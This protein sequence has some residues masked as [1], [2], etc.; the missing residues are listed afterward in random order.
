MNKNALYTSLSRATHEDLIHMDELYTGIY[1]PQECMTGCIEST[2]FTDPVWKHGKIY[3]VKVG[4]KY[5][6]GETVK[7]LEARLKEH[8]EDPESAVFQEIQEHKE[9]QIDL[10]PTIELI[11]NFPC[12]SNKELVQCES[13]YIKA[14]VKKYG[15]E[16]MLNKKQLGIEKE[17]NTI[18]IKV[19]RKLHTDKFKVSDSE[20]K[21]CFRLRYRIDG[22]RKEECFQYRSQPKDEA[23]AMVEARQ[24]EVATFFDWD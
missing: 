2:P 9:N 3:R 22:K 7:K 17:K 15:R 23:M 24:K 21:G 5:Y 10:K 16:R 18:E 19:E 1:T 13:K 20:V 11:C 6:V 4:N 12:F 14:Y 8:I